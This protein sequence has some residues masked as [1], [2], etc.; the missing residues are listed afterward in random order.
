MP[1]HTHVRMWTLEGAAARQHTRPKD[2]H[3][4]TIR[5]FSWLELA[6]VG[7]EAE[8]PSTVDGDASLPCIGHSV[9]LWL[10][11]Y[12]FAYASRHQTNTIRDASQAALVRHASVSLALI[13]LRGA[14]QHRSSTEMES[15]AHVVEPL[16]PGKAIVTTSFPSCI[17]DHLCGACLSVG[18]PSCRVGQRLPS[19]PAVNWLV[20]KFIFSAPIS[21]DQRQGEEKSA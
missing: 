7:A 8:G 19:S 6:G 18:V 20:K 11:A 21:S 9:A 15:P 10:L 3:Y 5:I 2:W 12:L 1:T 17:A 14:P 13:M 16:C 4:W